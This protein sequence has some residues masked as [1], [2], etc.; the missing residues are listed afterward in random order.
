MYR[1]VGLLCTFLV[2]IGPVALTAQTQELKFYHLTTK[3]GLSQT[4]INCIMKDSRGFMWFGTQDGLNRYDGYT[5]TVFRN[6]PEDSNS[7]SDNY[8]N[9]LAEDPQGRIWIGTNVGGLNVYDPVLNK[10]SRI[11]YKEDDPNSLCDNKVFSL[12]IAGNGKLYVG[13]DNGLNIMEGN[14][15]CR[16]KPDSDKPKSLIDGSIRCITEDKKGNIWLGTFKGGLHLFDEKNGW[17]DYFPASR[18]G[19]DGVSEKS[20]RI[21]TIYTDS[22]GLFWI[23]SGN[24][25]T[26]IFDPVGR[27]YRSAFFATEDAGAISNNWVLAFAEDQFGKLWIATNDSGLCFYD[28]RTGLFSRQYSDE[29]NPLGLS[30]NSLRSLLCDESGNMW[31]GTSTSG[32]NVFFRNTLKFGHFRRKVGSSNTLINNIVYAIHRDRQGVIWFCSRGAELSSYDK[33]TGK[34]QHYPEVCLASNRTILTI[35]EDASGLLYLGSWGGGISVF[36]KKKGIAVPLNDDEF[37]GEVLSNKTVLHLLEDKTGKLWISTFGGGVYRFDKTSYKLE[38]LDSEDGLTHNRVHY[39]IQ[40]KTG[41]IW[42][43]TQGGISVIDPTTFKV[44]KTFTAGSGDHA[45]TS[46]TVYSFFEDKKGNVWIATAIGLNKFDPL[47]GKISRFYQKDGLANDNI[48]GILEDKKGD[49][50]LSTNKGISRF[51]PTTSNVNGSAFKNYE[52]IDGLQEGEFL[53][54][55]FFKDPANGEM[56]FGGND[57]FNFFFP[58]SISDNKHIPPVLLTSFKRFGKEVQ[59]DTSILDKKYIELSYRDNFFSFEFVS[60]DYTLPGKNLYSYKME[61]VD[62]DWSAPSNLRFA[63]YTN[64]EGGDY[65]FRVRASNNDGLWNEEGAVIHIRVIPPIYKTKTFYAI[66]IVLLLIGIWGFTKW[67]TRAI[68]MEKRV[69]EEKVAE[70]TAE[71]AQKNRDITSSIQYAKRIQE[72]ILPELKEIRKI[73]PDSFVLFKPKDIV[74]GDFYWFGVRE[75]KAIIAAVDCTGHGVP[76]AFMSMIGNNL[77]SQIIMEKGITEPDRILNELNAGV[78]AALRQGIHEVDTKDGMDVAL[79]VIDSKEREVQF[80]GAFRPLV[81]VREGE[82]EKVDGNKFP[83]GG[84]QMENE[85]RFTRVSRKLKKGDTIY[86]FSDG[87]ADQFGGDKGKKFMVK[88]LNELFMAIQDLGMNSQ[89]EELERTIEE[90]KGIHEQ[91]DDILVIGVRL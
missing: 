6:D 52:A 36:D 38:G 89:R 79:C 85:R 58:E 54:G 87:Y 10:F 5:F 8:I 34:F 57:G 90:W 67:R 59:L 1:F 19:L 68:E 18:S 72:A 84:A 88:K 83:I 65:I 13:T 24:G 35:H 45:I 23:G 78:Q 48:Y 50:W 37:V 12:L 29:Y 53:Q 63:S 82:L 11:V 56:F 42:V 27:T 64:L 40:D 77:L 33:N 3:Q 26:F 71:L 17:F 61:G 2:W 43:A 80:A 14:T 51:S 73:L 69:L 32:I 55:S 76:G 22:Q 7:I 60:L 49:L 47:S 16:I 28:R 25:G 86:M 31:V 74:S 41:K 20:D 44:V 91:V 75:G 70:R 46:N 66:C 81:I 39:C 30:S 21:R 9:C 62:E 15:L 4:V